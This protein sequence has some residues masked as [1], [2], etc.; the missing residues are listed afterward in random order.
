MAPKVEEFRLPLLYP[1]IA[2]AELTQR[3]PAKWVV[4]TGCA[5][6][7]Q[8]PSKASAA[9]TRATARR[10]AGDVKRRGTSGP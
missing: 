9:P 10:S 3:K 7:H 8:P 4:R 1:V 6:S 5:S 2:A